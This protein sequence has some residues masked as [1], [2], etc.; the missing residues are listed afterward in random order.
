MGEN[1]AVSRR[2]IV[3]HPRTASARRVDRRRNHGSQVRGFNVTNDEV[4]ALV[5]VQRRA[6]IGYLLTLLVP[7]G[8]G[9]LAL[10]LIPG[11]VDLRLRGIPLPWLLIGPVL[12]LWIVLIAW[13]HDR[14]A[15]RTEQRW[16]EANKPASSPGNYQ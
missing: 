1:E 11:L 14:R 5:D 8:L 12:L 15:L 6:A 16:S 10:V 4:F 7:A 9:L 3:L 13:R 2:R